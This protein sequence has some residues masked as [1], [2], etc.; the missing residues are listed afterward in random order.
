MRELI[1]FQTLVTSNEGNVS[2]LDLTLSNDA[3]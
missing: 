3:V 1:L 2:E